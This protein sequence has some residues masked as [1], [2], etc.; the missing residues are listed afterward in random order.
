VSDLPLVILGAGGFGREAFDVVLAHNAASGL[1]QRPN[2]FEMLGFLDDGEPD[3]DR[4]ARQGA[5]HLGPTSS[6]ADYR[7]CFYLIGVADPTVRRRLAG[8]ADA[9][10][11]Q[12]VTV[13]HPSAAIGTQLTV[14]PGTVICS[15][16]SVSTN[17]LLGPHTHLNPNCVIG[18]DCVLTDYVTVYPGATIS[19]N[20]TLRSQVQVGTG[21]AIVQGLTIGE[22]TFVGAGAA[23]VDDLHADVVAVGVP[24]RPLLKSQKRETGSQG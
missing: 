19:G 24:A 4:L 11:L 14:A 20:V 18:H 2:V 15:H 3:P 9:G 6:L 1:P 23:V 21:A 12:A 10:G 22:R 17:V 5:R 7:G 13:I 8:E 16:V